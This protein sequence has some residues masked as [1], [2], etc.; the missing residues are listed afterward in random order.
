[1]KRLRKFLLA[2]TVA[3]PLT[4]LVPQEQADASTI[5]LCLPDVAVNPSGP[6]VVVNTTSAAS[7]Q[8]TYVFGPGGCAAVAV[9]DVG[10]L[11]AQGFTQPGPLFAAVTATGVLTGTT[12]LQIATLP[13]SAYIRDIYVQNSTA[14]AVTGG[15]SIG[16]SSGAGDISSALVCGASCLT[17][18][19]DAGVLKR[20][21]SSTAQQAV[22]ATPVTAGNNAN[23]TITITYGYF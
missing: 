3:L 8:P 23:L 2:T 11:L 5:W 15:V 21:F 16:S 4:L 19:T 22:F 18:V 14:N 10:F 17:F 20:V 1:M 6:R 13:A 12:S 9:A 7:P